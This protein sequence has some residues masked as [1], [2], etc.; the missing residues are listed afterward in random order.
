MDKDIIFQLK[1]EDIKIL[2]ELEKTVVMSVNL[3][4]SALTTN[5]EPKF[6]KHNSEPYFSFLEGLEQQCHYFLNFYTK[7]E[8]SINEM[9]NEK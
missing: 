9:K 3:I 2:S 6:A 4:N 5:P 7:L 1:N 8:Y